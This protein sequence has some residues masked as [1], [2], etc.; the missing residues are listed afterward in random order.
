MARKSIWIAGTLLALILV[1]AAG[2]MG[3]LRTDSGRSLLVRAA[4]TAADSQGWAL[5][6]GRL[7]GKLPFEVMVED[8]SVGDANGAFLRLGRARLNLDA[9]ALLDRRLAFETIA[10]EDVRVLRA[11]ETP[12][13]AADAAPKPDASPSSM[14]PG[15]P[16]SVRALSVMPL[17]LEPALAGE[18]VSLAVTAKSSVHPETGIDAGFSIA[19]L[20]GDGTIEGR[21]ASDAALSRLSASIK[22]ES[23]EGGWISKL[24]GLPGYPGITVTLDGDGPV[25]GF[26]ARFGITAGETLGA[27]GV[28]RLSSLQP[29]A[30][31]VEGTA[32]VSA[33]VPQDLRPAL[34]GSFSYALAASLDPDMTQ[35]TVTALKI[36]AAE[37]SASG[38]ASLDLAAGTLEADL[39]ADLRNT[40]LP[41]DLVP[42]LSL[43]A[44]G[45]RV[46]LSGPLLK[47]MV[48]AGFHADGPA[49]AGNGA[50]RLE[51]RVEAEFAAGRAV[52][53]EGTGSLTVS[54][55]AIPGM[56]AGAIGGDLTADT[57]F[58][59]SDGMLILSGFRAA[60][61]PAA[62]RGDASVNT[63]TGTV[64]FSAM[65]THDAL[66]AVVPGLKSGRL[67]ADLH[68]QFDGALLTLQL[69]GSARNLGTGDPGLDRVLAGET[70]LWVS[71]RQQSATLWELSSA[72]IDNP[73]ARI[74]A[75]GLVDQAALTGDV[76]A[77]IQMDDLARLDPSGTLEAGAARLGAAI[78]GGLETAEMT[79]ELS[80][81]GLAAR[82]YEIPRVAAKGSL[83][84][85]GLAA[86]GDAAISAETPLGPAEARTGLAWDGR[87][88]AFTDITVRRGGDTVGGALSLMPSPLAVTG[89]LDVAIASLADWGKLAGVVIDGGA[90]ARLEASEA[91][92]KQRLGWDVASRAR[93]AGKE[94][95]TVDRVD[96]SGTLDDAFGDPRL[97]ATVTVTG[98]ARG[99]VR[100][101]RIDLSAHGALDAPAFEL[102]A[103]GAAS[104]IPLRGAAAGSIALGDA[105]RLA[106]SRF[107]LAGREPMI[108][109][110]RPGGATLQGDGGVLEPLSLALFGGKLEA[111]GSVKDGR[112]AGQ[113]AV[114]NVS[115]PAVATL[116]GATLT[117]GT[118]NASG[119]LSGPLATPNGKLDLALKDVSGFGSADAGLPP[120]TLA[121]TAR[122]DEG[123][124][125]ARASLSGIGEVPFE[126][127]LATRLPDG[128][129]V[130]PLEAGLQWRGSLGN[131]AAA[132]PL[133]GN[134]IRGDAEID[135]AFAGGLDTSDGSV[136]PDRTS[137]R[138][139]LRDGRVENFLSGA[140]LDPLS[141]S[142]T[143]D[144]TRL[145]IQSFEA[146]DTGGGTARISGAVDLA[147]PSRPKLALEAVLREMTVAR[148]D[149]AN[150]QLDARI[151][152]NS[153]GE[154]ILV[155]GEITNHKTEIQLVGA[156][157]AGV[158]ELAVEEVRDG[159]PVPKDEEASAPPT[160]APPVDLDLKFT[161][162]G[163]IFVRGRGLDS[164][165]GGEVEI[166]GTVAAP[167]LLGSIDPVRGGFEF[168]GRRFE[169]GEGG[170]G[171][172]GGETIEPALNLSAI[173][174]G[175]D[176]TAVARI[177][178]SASQPEIELTSDP[179]YPED[180]ILAK[181][182]FGKFTARLT[183]TEAL[184]LAQS[185]RTLLSGEPGALD[186]IRGALG[187][188]VLTFA[189]GAS[190]NELGRLKAGKY[191]RDDLFVGVEQGTAAGS[192]R[193]VVE[194]NLTPKITVEGTVG[195]S[196]ESTLG[197]QRRWEY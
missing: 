125:D 84:A 72:E 149:D 87:R 96:V 159:K 163:K 59:F 154:R 40:S 102:Q 187:V 11:P 75:S 80:A 173:H 152:V 60:S 53:A 193:S 82:G 181:I 129:P 79:W 158:E 117:A 83:H 167:R 4:V 184:Q 111:A 151:A 99:Q 90:T 13:S 142:V 143:L 57:Q 170:I 67:E 120:V 47:P 146:G 114:E 188:D 137:G 157:P 34:S 19:R 95:T 20:D 138:I 161:A 18:T 180:E 76:T 51:G 61:G 150:V 144:G 140:I 128:D 122:L 50:A 7:S 190:E 16:I 81:T 135:L 85:E 175:A 130:V 155:S 191:V 37:A 164:E 29:L 123:A 118:L 92:G 23:A 32:T 33:L 89:A 54:G 78:K 113:L 197:I 17:V 189:P 183:A 86:R 179:P 9:G 45:L 147:E 136:M 55:L 77:E 6:I 70:A 69:G 94:P 119:D 24:L 71:A 21:L 3:L 48:K 194:W 134:L 171:F 196:S 25:A 44:A 10:L 62:I 148:R 168:A 109:L 156:L 133:D 74:S 127:R 14:L 177:T 93:I 35:V 97:N 66:A 1:I 186:K 182:L 126:A 112:V 172:S 105:P 30:L 42:G 104:G 65:A 98:A 15:I 132:L 56:P 88:L 160:E 41:G 52:S 141:A 162:P 5:S 178:G 153:K 145:V 22:G 116:F 169:L 39:A 26:E 43:A 100:A 121:V 192:T 8:V 185:T 91:G 63:G 107:E 115:L 31:N 165:W 49:Y 28:I 36:D 176:F 12:A 64:D 108:R 73:G 139:L 68:G 46:A 195:S 38:S 101:E 106:L 110:L 131:L 58:G 27:Q 124:L 166:S 103:S 2:L 174:R